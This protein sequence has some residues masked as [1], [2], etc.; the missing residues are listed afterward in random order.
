MQKACETSMPSWKT[1][2]KSLSFQCLSRSQAYISGSPAVEG[3]LSSIALLKPGIPPSQGS[4]LLLA[5][6]PAESVGRSSCTNARLESS[7]E[8]EQ[9]FT[10]VYNFRGSRPWSG[11][12]V[13]SGPEVG[14]H[15]TGGYTVE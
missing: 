9:R 7:T 15:V 5:L 8:K 2:E 3:D 14:Q 12:L 4:V 6:I 13:D 10:L 1:A 11:D